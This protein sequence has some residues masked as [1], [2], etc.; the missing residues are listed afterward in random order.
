MT[1]CQCVSTAVMV[2]MFA[3]AFP[4]GAM[5]A[6]PG[7][8]RD[9][10]SG[11]LRAAVD[12]AATRAV[13]EHQLTSAPGRPAAQNGA[14]LQSTGGGGHVAMIIKRGMDSDGIVRRFRTERQ[15]LAGLNHPNIA[16][17][18]DGG[19]TLDGLPYLVLE[20]VDGEPITAF[21]EPG[22]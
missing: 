19:S 10:R 21:C 8:P 3:A 13:A 14:R 18:L 1:I 5:A 22:R 16:R 2:A 4:A 6:D 20:Y 15:I 17:L 7:Q 9:G 11:S 12:R